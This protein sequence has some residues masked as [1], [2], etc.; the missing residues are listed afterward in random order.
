[1]EFYEEVLIRFAQNAA[2][3]AAEINKFYI[4]KDFS[5]YQIRVH[6]LKSS[7]KMIGADS[8][9]EMARK[10]E[11]AAKYHNAGYIEEQHEEILTGYSEMAQ[12][13]L[14]ALDTGENDS[15]QEEPE[16]H[17]EIS[18]DELIQ[19]L[20]ELKGKLDTFEADMAENIISGMSGFVYQG[21]TMENL[22]YDVRQDVEDFELG[23]AS[24]KVEALVSSM[25]GREA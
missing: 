24:E 25:K 2:G 14:D 18:T 11:E 15:V 20:E 7:A 1:M 6:A 13:I 4:E 23:A 3:K 21:T 16:N 22:L 17:T 12:H 5:N 19:R 9:S 10:A 8:L